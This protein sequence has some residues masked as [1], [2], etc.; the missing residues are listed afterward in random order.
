MVTNPIE[1]HYYIFTV[2]THKFAGTMTMYRRRRGRSG[3]VFDFLD[4]RDFWGDSDRTREHFREATD[5][6][7]ITHKLTGQEVVFSEREQ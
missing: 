5:L 3:L 6:E 4:R 1:G 2:R 7:V